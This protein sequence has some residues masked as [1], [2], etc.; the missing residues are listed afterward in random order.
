MIIHMPAAAV[1]SPVRMYS[2]EDRGGAV[3]EAP[4]TA[5][6]D[7]AY[8]VDVTGLVGRYWP[9]VVYT[10]DGDEQTLDLVYVDLPE[11]PELVVSPEQVAQKAVPKIPPPLTA[12][13]R[14]TIT[15]AILDA[16]S[17]AASYLGRGGV[18]PGVYTESGRYDDGT[19]RWNLDLL[20]EPLI[21][22]LDATPETSGGVPTGLYT[23]TYRAGIDAKNDPELRPIK[24][25]ITAA[26]LNAPEVVALWRQV[27]KPKGNVKSVTTEG[28]SITYDAP[29]LGGGGKG[30]PGEL[31]SKSSMDR[32]RLAGRRAFQRTTVPRPP[33]PHSSM[34]SR[35]GYR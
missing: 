8:Q 24:R 35:W 6:S 33:W 16:Q 4:V 11:A 20:D 7:T 31:P 28:Q 1:P 26:A 12:E 3:I 9:T 15:E 25:Y 2:T 32:W 14:E 17:D 22:V 27:A 13:Q 30:Q 21:E 29:G 19:G 23:I 10:L 5:V 18:V 34:S